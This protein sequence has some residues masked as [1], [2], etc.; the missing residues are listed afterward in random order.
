MPSS[1]NLDVVT[2]GFEKKSRKRGEGRWTI[3]RINECLKSVDPFYFFLA[4]VRGL[5]CG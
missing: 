3:S 1:D 2:G 4:R 5:L